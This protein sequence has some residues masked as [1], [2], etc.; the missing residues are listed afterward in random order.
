MPTLV[1]W[2]I[3]LASFT[4]K[5]LE[6][7]GRVESV[8]ERLSM[9]APWAERAR[10]LI[11]PSGDTQAFQQYEVIF[12]SSARRSKYVQSRKAADRSCGRAWPYTEHYSYGASSQ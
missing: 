12:W 7:R 9:L 8:E 4:V 6:I 3:G 10:R 2:L 1:A 11:D 5:I